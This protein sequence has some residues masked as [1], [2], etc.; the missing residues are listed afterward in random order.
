VENHPWEHNSIH[1]DGVVLRVGPERA[2]PRPSDAA[3]VARDGDIVEID[4]STYE[5]DAAV[6]TQ[7]RLTLRGVGGRAHLRANGAH[8]EAK[9][10]WVI[11]GANT[12]IENIEF[13]GAAVQHRNGA[14]IRQEG[15]GLTVRDCNFHGNENGILTGSNPESD[16]LIER[17][18][19][20][21]NGHGDGYSHNI[22]IGAVRSFTLRGSYV[23]RAVVGHNVK[24]R[25]LRN[26][27]E[28]NRIMDY[29]D[30]RASYNIDLP[31]GGLSY[32]IGNVLHQG[33][34]TENDALI[35]YGAEGLRGSGDE[36]YV[37]NNTLVN[38]RSG[39]GRFI[40]VKGNATA[41]RIVN[42][43]FL[44]PGEL[45]SGVGEMRNNMRVNTESFVAPESFDYR[46]TQRSPAINAG[47][48]PGHASSVPLIPVAEYVHQSRNLI[49]RHSGKALDLG[50]LG[51]RGERP[52]P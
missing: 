20:W 4:A 23:H 33:P 31:N 35:A 1:S 16:I 44:G 9:A 22:Y 45:L 17:T 21:R 28:Y 26:H 42:N 6:W 37:I 19:F 50:A 10:I 34:A 52:L 29:E 7:D 11:K 15:P 40:F 30:G 39:G 49:R 24:S 12:T 36:L 5:G 27:I 48:D 41:V 25:A 2:L 3:K 13:S 46:L 43:L 38:D 47:I 14:G 32:V 18:E 8:A 51:Y